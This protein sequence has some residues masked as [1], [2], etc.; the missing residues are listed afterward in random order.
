M[1]RGPI[2]HTLLSQRINGVLKM[3]IG[4]GMYNFATEKNLKSYRAER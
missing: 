4:F 2:A 3:A 1:H